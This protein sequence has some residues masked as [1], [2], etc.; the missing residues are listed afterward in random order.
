MEAD[1]GELLQQARHDH[2]ATTAPKGGEKPK[3]PYVGK[4]GAV[5]RGRPPSATCLQSQRPGQ[6]PLIFPADEA[7][8]LEAI[9]PRAVN[10][11]RQHQK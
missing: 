3:P 8:G 6:T 11:L 7:W 2:Q 4:V 5:R 1:D 10:M 9:H